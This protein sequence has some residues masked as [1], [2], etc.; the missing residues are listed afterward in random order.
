MNFSFES[1][2]M[3]TLNASVRRQLVTHLYRELPNEACG[4]LLGNLDNNVLHID[5]LQPI[6]N[7]AGNPKHAFHLDPSGWISCSF[8]PHLIG[9][10]HTHPTSSPTPS[11]EDL[12]QLQLFGEFIHIYLIA[13]PITK[14]G[15]PDALIHAYSVHRNPHSLYYLEPLILTQ[16][17]V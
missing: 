2:R 14:N 17:N 11:A 12:M 15:E 10:F 9:I 6:R 1:D 5:R 16:E 7:T 3:Y 4:A 8:H 13:S